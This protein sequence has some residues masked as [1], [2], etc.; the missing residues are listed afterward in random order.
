MREHYWASSCV[1][2][3]Q[4]SESSDLNGSEDKQR[5]I[6]YCCPSLP[7]QRVRDSM[8]ED[9]M[10][11]PHMKMELLQTNTLLGLGNQL[12]ICSNR[13]REAVWEVKLWGSQT[14]ISRNWSRKP[15]NNP[16]NSPSKVPRT[17][18]RTDSFPNCRLHFQL[19]INQKKPN[20]YP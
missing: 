17:W 13:P 10:A 2:Q 5:H 11:R 4:T 6:L 15:N 9:I 12:I 19:R 18:R 20:M 7:Q 3:I 14:A 16:C 8:Y 1:S